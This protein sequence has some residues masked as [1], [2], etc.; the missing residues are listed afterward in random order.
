MLPKHV[1]AATAPE[2]LRESDFNRQPIGSGPFV[3]NRFQVV[4]PDEGRLIIY[5]E[6]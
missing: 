1:L 5:L 2:R 4:N 6:K 3:F